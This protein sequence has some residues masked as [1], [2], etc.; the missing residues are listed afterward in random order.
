MLN[1]ITFSFHLQFC[2][3]YFIVGRAAGLS[4]SYAYYLKTVVQD[5]NSQRFIFFCAIL[6]NRNLKEKK[7]K[8][9]QM[10]SV[11]NV[12]FYHVYFSLFWKAKEIKKERNIVSTNEV[13]NHFYL[14]FW[15]NKIFIKLLMHCVH[16]FRKKKEYTASNSDYGVLCLAP[17]LTTFYPNYTITESYVMRL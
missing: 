5:K 9:G 15:F 13:R 8:K 3:Q 7:K 17:S 10:L 11:C 14:H 12:C 2:K 16:V 4:T 6:Y 1:K